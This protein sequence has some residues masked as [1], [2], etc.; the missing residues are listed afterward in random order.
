L[1]IQDE[2]MMIKVGK[3]GRRKGR[4]REGV[5]ER[6]REQEKKRKREQASSNRYSVIGIV[7]SEQ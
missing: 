7:K 4:K 6:G 5:M 1:K 2:R 3:A